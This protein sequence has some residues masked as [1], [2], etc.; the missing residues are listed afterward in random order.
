MYRS[1]IRP[2]LFKSLRD[3]EDAHEYTLQLL[4]LLSRLPLQHLHG[5]R[6]PRLE[7]EV[8]GVRFPNPVGLAAGMDKNGVAL[9]AWAALGCGFVEV[10]TVTWMA[11]PGNV[12][13]RLYRL[14]DD[15]ALINRMGFNNEGALA[16][17][18]RLARGSA[19]GIPIGISLG[20]S[21]LTALAAATG[22]YCA[23]LRALYRYGSYFAINISSP[24]T[25]GL[26]ALQDRAQ[27]AHLLAA[28]QAENR[29]QSQ[30]QH[31]PP[32]PLLVKVA[33]D[34]SAAALSELLAVCADQGVSGIIATNT[35][36]EPRV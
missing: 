21:K 4:A 7:R 9:P 20:K 35:T 12:R 36:L 17:A 19:L 31:R 28:L 32:R 22:D 1:F 33:P 34:L 24:N 23:A 5:P 6:D 26:R 30:L 25:P 18:H 3:A 14:Q 10:G 29:S 15:D 11:Q 8:F 2:L 13:P 16:L 27:L